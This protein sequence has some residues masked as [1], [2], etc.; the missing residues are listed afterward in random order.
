[1]KRTKVDIPLKKIKYIHHISDVHIRNLKRH[2]EYEQVFEKLYKKIKQ[3]RED[4]II[5]IGGDIAHS[6]TDMSPELV[7]QTSRFLKSLSEICPTIVITGNHD[8]NL[9][10]LNR[11][12][13]LTPIINNL[14]LPNLHYLKRSG[15]YDIADMSFVVWDVWEDEE[16]YIKASD[17][18]ADTKVVLY[19]GTVDRSKTDVGFSLP[20]KVTIDYFDGYDLGLIGDIHKRQ[21]LDKEKTIAYCGSLIQQNHGE[22]IGHGYLLWEVETKKSE[23]IEIPNDYGY[24]TIDIDKGIVPDV[25]GMPKKARLRVRVSNTNGIELKKALAIIHHRYG[26]KDVTI[27]KVDRRDVGRSDSEMVIG[28]VNDTDYQY[29]LIEDYLKRN[30]P[31]TDNIL[32]KI[33]KLN[34]EI[35]NELPPA[36]VKRNINWKLKNFEFSNMFCYGEDNYVDF[37][38]LEGIVGM[39]APNASGKST[40]LDALSF[41]LFDIT[42]RT[43]KAASVLN[44]KKKSFNCKVNF[45]VAGLDYFIERKATTRSRDRHVKVEV[46]FWM[47]DDGGDIISLNGDQRRTTN[48]NINR[49]IGTYDDFILSTLSTQN[50]FTVFIDKTQKERKELLAT[51]MG[52]DIFDTLY[53]SANDKI[54]ETQTLLRD[55][56]KVDYGKILADLQKETTILEVNQTNLLSKKDGESKVYNDLNSQIINLT[57]QLK[58]VDDTIRDINILEKENSD[59]EE[60]LDKAFNEESNV[61]T[62]QYDLSQVISDLESKIK[63]Y[64]KDNVQEKYAELEKLEQERNIFAVELDKLKADVRVKLDKIDKLKGVTYDPDCEHCMSNPL[65]LDAIETEKNLDKDVG[66]SKEYMKKKEGMDTE[67]EKMFKVRAFK[68][69]LDKAKSQLSEGKLRE[70]NL[71]YGLQYINER[72]QNIENQIQSTNNEIKRYKEQE[73]NIKFNDSIKSKITK[74]ELELSDVDKIISKLNDNITEVHSDIKVNDNEMKNINKKIKEIH[75]LEKQNQ[76]YHYYLD[77][78]RRDSIPYELLA[79]AIPTIEGEVNN[80]LSQLVDFQMALEMDG[81]NINSNIVYDDVNQ[82]PLELSSGMERFISSLAMRV[83]LINVSNLPRSNFLAIDEGW[84]TMDSDNINSVYNL[85]QYLK[86][87]FQFTLIVSHVDSMRDAVD[88]LLEITKD[89]DFSKIK[90]D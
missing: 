50:N 65:T 43:N 84:G 79:K 86:T 58:P 17:F 30:H 35:N 52:T 29:E 62:E 61:V 34:E 14:N 37:T 88:T 41:C 4:S 85:F 10:N 16:D 11:L 51:F 15:V 59:N 69:E 81:K 31:I 27:T 25:K 89:T 64:E 90:F 74:K 12:D 8:C 70:D 26:I 47:V 1:M 40:L 83:G 48:Y 38:Q 57:T 39:F 53:Q 5:Y 45:E 7:D 21:Y 76:A 60:L 78:V 63:I 56:N 22:S 3:N 28:D 13:V 20:G 75:E 6:K 82:W 77:A 80:I 44:N 42:S 71:N 66:L 67:I 9:N 33:K 18:E 32:V 55:F 46:N 54:S 23:Y 87:Q 2:A 19:H 49:V 68:E 24:Y 72:K 36:R 73:N